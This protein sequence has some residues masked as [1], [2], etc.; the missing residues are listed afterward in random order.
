MLDMQQARL[1]F[2]F[3]RALYLLPLFTAW[4]QWLIFIRF[5][6]STRLLPDWINLPRHGWRVVSGFESFAES[7]NAR[8]KRTFGIDINFTE[9]NF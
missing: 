3:P 8:E 4:F 5:A 6:S 2:I 1:R 9:I 7:A